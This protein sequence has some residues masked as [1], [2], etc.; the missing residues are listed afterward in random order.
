MQLCTDFLQKADARNLLQHRSNDLCLHEQR[1]G[2]PFKFYCVY[3]ILDYFDFL[4]FLDSIESTVNACECYGTCTNV[5]FSIQGTNTLHWLQSNKLRFELNRPKMRLVREVL[6][7]YSDVIGKFP[8]VKCFIFSM[9]QIWT[10]KIVFF[11]AAI[12]AVYSLFLGT[13]IL[14]LIEI[15]YCGCIHRFVRQY[16]RLRND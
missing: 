9:I 3:S 4:S 6:H 13:G 1:F 15:F 16:E 2:S 7:S 12:G 14:T 11:P 8:F 10:P 5:K